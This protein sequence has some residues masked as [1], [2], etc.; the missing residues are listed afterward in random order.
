M[1]ADDEGVDLEQA[2]LATASIRILI[3]ALGANLQILD[4]R[5][6]ATGSHGHQCLYYQDY[7]GSGTAQWEGIM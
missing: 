3:L 6:Q 5:R 1:A 2:L 7:N 4:L